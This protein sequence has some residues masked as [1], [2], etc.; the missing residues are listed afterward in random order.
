MIDAANDL[1]QQI[2]AGEMEAAGF[3]HSCIN[4]FPPVP[5]YVIRG[6]SDFGDDL[7]DDRFHRLAA[8]AVAAYTTL[9]ISQVLDL[10]I[11]IPKS[12]NLC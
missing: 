7:K 8:S 3:V 11:W 6:I 1:H 2:R 10:R 5:W 4:A 9:Y 12:E